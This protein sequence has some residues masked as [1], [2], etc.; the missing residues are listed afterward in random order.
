[1]QP[2]DVA[3][4]VLNANEIKEKEICKFYFPRH[5]LTP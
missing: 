4:R 3:A 2:K 1:M 5:P